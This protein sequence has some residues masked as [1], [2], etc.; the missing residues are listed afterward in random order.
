MAKEVEKV[1]AVKDVL[2]LGSKFTADCDCSHVNGNSKMVNARMNVF[3]EPK[4]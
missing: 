4:L 3:L 1:E 2:F